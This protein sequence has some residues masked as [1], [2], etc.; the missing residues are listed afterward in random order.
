MDPA[1]IATISYIPPAVVRE[2]GGSSLVLL[3]VGGKRAVREGGA[4]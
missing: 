4:A 3:E 1:M 2:R